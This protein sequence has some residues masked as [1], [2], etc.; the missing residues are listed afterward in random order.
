VID[1]TTDFQRIRHRMRD[2]D[3]SVVL[4]FYMYDHDSVS[5]EQYVYRSS[6]DRRN[7]HYLFIQ[8]TRRQFSCQ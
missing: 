1:D 8:S 3:V 6:A 4:K 2:V 7:K 5:D